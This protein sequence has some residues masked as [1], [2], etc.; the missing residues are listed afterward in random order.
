MEKRSWPLR[1]LDVLRQE[2][3][4]LNK[5][6]TVHQARLSL[7]I[8]LLR[9]AQPGISQNKGKTRGLQ[10]VEADG[11]VVLGQEQVD[12][13]GLVCHRSQNS[14]VTRSILNC[15]A[16]PSSIKEGSAPVSRKGPSGRRRSAW[17]RG[18][19]KEEDG[20][21]AWLIS[22]FLFTVESPDFY[23]AVVSEATP[24]QSES[25]PDVHAVFSPQDKNRGRGTRREGRV[26]WK[27]KQLQ[28]IGN[29]GCS[30]TAT[31]SWFLQNYSENLVN[32][33]LSTKQLNNKVNHWLVNMVQPS[34]AKQ[35]DHFPR[36]IKSS[37]KLSSRL[38]KHKSSSLRTKT[39]ASTFRQ[40]KAF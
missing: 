32:Y 12:R 11:L 34:A 1:A 19:R 27:W 4:K 22:T 33:L 23:R 28:E 26:Q 17:R 35:T 38:E 37:R 18:L 5:A 36:S 2:G 25:P 24:L 7:C 31:G 39:R 8:Y 9:I 20:E 16:S 14:T 13:N 3:I 21:V 30:L 15:I 6:C 29:R 40:R 10:N